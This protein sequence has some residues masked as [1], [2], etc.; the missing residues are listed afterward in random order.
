MGDVLIGLDGG[1]TH[2]RVL[3]SDLRGSFLGYG[4]DAGCNPEYEPADACVAHAKAALTH[5]LQASGVDPARVCSFAAGIAGLTSVTGTDEWAR[6]IAGDLGLGGTLTLVGDNKV[7]QVGAFGGAPGIVALGGTGS[8]VS[9]VTETGR[10]VC[11]FDLRHNAQAGAWWLSSRLITRIAAEEDSAADAALVQAVLSVLRCPDRQG[12]RD[13][14]VGG[15][16]EMDISALAPLATRWATDGSPLARATC[17]ETAHELARGVRLLAPFFRDRP[18][19]VAPVGSVASSSYVQ[20]ALGRSLAEPAG[21]F[22]VAPPLYPPVVGAVLLAA[23]RLG[24][25]L[26]PDAARR[27]AHRCP[28][29]TAGAEGSDRTEARAPALMD[30]GSAALSRW[31]AG[32]RVMVTIRAAD[33][34]DAA[35]IARVHIDSWRTAYRGLVPNRYLS[36]LSYDESERTWHRILAVVSESRL[37]VAHV[38]GAGV[39]GFALGGPGRARDPVDP[40]YTGELWGIHILEAYQRR[41]IGRALVR[42]VARWLAT[43]GMHSMFVWFLQDAPARHFYEVLGGRRLQTK[44]IEIGGAVLAYTAYGWLDTSI[45]TAGDADNP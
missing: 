35:A 30:A 3:V 18:V 13:A 24:T 20:G 27:L 31:G 2:T 7:A 1:G 42:A 8:I 14:L 12:M 23:E 44:Q 22:R 39:V 38:D 10:E 16:V 19:A 36:E 32:D 21:R 43:Q 9:A 5:A 34:R 33:A 26:P 45:L 40:A 41:G 15:R 25:M 17:D 29:P 6:P 11:N 28:A 37:V 4:E